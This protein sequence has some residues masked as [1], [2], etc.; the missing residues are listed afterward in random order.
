MAI[1]HAHSG[2]VIDLRPLGAGLKQA[3]TTTVVKTDHVE[4]I[5]LIL[6][7]GKEIP[8]HKVSGEILVQ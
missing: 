7:A 6:H 2:Q 5:R 4:V 1:P 8:H 3:V